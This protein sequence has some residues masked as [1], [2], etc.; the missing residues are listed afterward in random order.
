LH[1]I[2]LDDGE[3]VGAVNIESPTGST[4][5]A[6]GS[7]IYFGTEGATFF[8]VDWKAIKEVW[9][10][11]EK[12]RKL[13]IRS[14]A[15]IT[16]ES[17]IFGGRDKVLHA[18]NPKSGEKLWDFQTKGKIDNSPVVVD[19]RIFFGSG[20]GDGRVYAVDLKT[21]NEVWRY[22]AGGSFAGSPALADGRLVIAS[23]DGMVYCFG[24][25]P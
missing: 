10:W 4:P 21:G 25:K 3:E 12:A 5:A 7:L 15:A 14:S 1:V 20:G 11:Q 24:A 18:L 17:V 22:E 23:E 13:P 19:Q 16:P 6:S 9:R 2:N 8:C